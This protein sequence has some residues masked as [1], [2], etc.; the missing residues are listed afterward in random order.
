M[1]GKR[2]ILAILF[3]LALVTGCRKEEDSAVSI[4]PRSSY[5]GPE[6]NVIFVEVTAT[7]SWTIELEFPSGTEAWASIDP[8]SGSGTK[9]DIRFRYSEN[10]SEEAREV[11]LV[12]WGQGVSARARV[13]QNG[14][15]NG[16]VG[17]Y[18]YGYD[19]APAALDWLELPALV[20]GDGR[21]LLIHNLSGGKYA[22]RAKDG[23]R[24][25]SCYWDY[26]DHMSLWVAYPH[27][28]SLRGNGSRTNQWGVYDPCIPSALQPNMGT[29]Y[30]NGWNRGH[31]IPSAD[32]L[33]PVSANVSTFYPT[34]MTPQDGSFNSKIWADLEGKVRN[35]SGS[36][37]DTLYVVTGAL[38]EAS[39]IT[40]PMQTGFAVKIPTH[41]FK[42]LLARTLTYGQD[43]YLAAGFILPHTSS[44]AGGNCLDYICSIDELEA[45]TG[46]DFF[47]N[48]IKVI[49]KEKADLVEAETPG[50][51]WK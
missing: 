18:G 10:T 35:Y 31:Q 17:E 48:L 46:I 4:V 38:F 14:V 15:D 25:W 36:V 30:G 29:Y 5:L 28:K 20:A 50:N 34:N 51:W 47:P 39:T 32:R 49:G 9:K 6:S 7:L 21:E 19:T 12:L 13:T 11:T 2:H 41:Y 16:K 37:T 24:N 22:G 43:G 45:Q 23:T 33:S 27:N 42:A 8:A 40:T 3:L 26:D 1:S 44:I